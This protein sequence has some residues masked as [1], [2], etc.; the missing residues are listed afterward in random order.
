L[1]FCERCGAPLFAVMAPQP[2]GWNPQQAVALP[3]PFEAPPKRIGLAILL[4]ALF[5]PLGLLYSSVLGA[6]SM[7]LASCFLYAAACEHWLSRD[8][9]SLFIAW[10][11]CIAWAGIAAGSFNRDHR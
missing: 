6:C 7:L 9:Y 8:F 4:A 5:G 3:Q 11:V 1:R 10:P 2:P